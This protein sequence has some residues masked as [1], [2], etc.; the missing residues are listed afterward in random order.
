MPDEPKNKMNLSKKIKI[1]I[2][3]HNL[4]ENRTG[5]GRYLQNILEQFSQMPSLNDQVIFY[6]YFKKKIPNDSFLQ[7][8]NLFILRLTKVP[9]FKAS[10]LVYFLILLPYYYFKDKL[11][12][13]WFPCYMVPITFWGKAILTIHDLV[14]ERFPG[15]VPFRYRIF[16]KIF[17]RFGAKRALKVLTVSD[18]SKQEIRFFYKIPSAK[19]EVTPLGL[20]K[21]FDHAVYLNKS[22]ARDKIKAKYYICQKYILFLGQI[23]QRRRPLEMIKAFY[24]I[25]HKFPDYQFL[26][27]G[28]NL[29]NPY[30]DIDNLCASFNKKLGRSVFL[31]HIYADEQD[32]IY[33]YRAAEL[34][35]YLSDYE[36]FGLPPLEAQRCGVPVISSK[37]S[38]LANILKKGAILIKDNT[39]IK[40]I[41]D[42]FKRILSDDKLA[43]KMSDEAYR[44]AET[45]D[46]KTTAQKTLRILF[47][48]AK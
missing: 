46:F 4:E 25:A 24:N 15:T 12:L 31:R 9:F 48:Y 35:I 39:S 45:Y 13:F 36:G 11:D 20:D 38:S 3:C 44:N 22:Q 18:F 42:A 7:S 8:S 21:K 34:F 37:S 30:L 16:Y 43:K 41:R 2:D 26:I 47:S 33:L 23:F 19:I 1:G 27:I 6:L 14:Y 17:S 29:T 32:L 10:F 40:E 28:R 5:V